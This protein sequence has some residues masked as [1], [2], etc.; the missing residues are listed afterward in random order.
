MPGF[1]ELAAGAML[2][3]LT[4]FLVVRVR[5]PRVPIWS[6]MSFLAFLSVA[7]GLVPVDSIGE[8]VNYD[9]VLFLIGMFS[10][11]SIAEHAGLLDYLSYRFLGAFRSRLGMMT[12]ASLLFGLLAAISVNDTVAMAGVP[13]ALSAAYSAGVDPEAMVLLLMFSLTVGSVFTPIGNPQNVLIAVESGMEAPFL[14]FVKYLAIPTLINLLLLPPIIMAFYRGAAEPGGGRE[15]PQLRDRRD[16]VIAAAG[17][18]TAVAALVVNDLLELRGLPHVQNVGFIPFVV[19]AGTYLFVRDPREALRGVEWGTVIFFISMFITMYGVWRSG[20]FYWLARLMMPSATSG[21]VGILQISAVSL[22]LSQLL[23]NVPFVNLFIEYMKGIGYGPGSAW[24][25][26]TLAYSSTIAG[27][28]TL[29][30]AA[31]NIIVLESLESRHG[32]TISFA[33]FAEVGAL[34]TLVNVAVYSAF[35]YLMLG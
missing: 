17:L 4:I 2:A 12:A 6:F 20:L 16:A 28:L 24:A 10:L 30:G 26:L 15:R 31:S 34:V 1:G 32:R 22:G 5:Y 14:T 23:S 29:L 18:S 25:W 11:V 9:V 33:R 19:A 3:S 21:M 8:A 7:L 35:I 13:I 27:N